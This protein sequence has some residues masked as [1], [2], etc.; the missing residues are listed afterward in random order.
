MTHSPAVI[1]AEHRE[2]VETL[3]NYHQMGHELRPTDVGIGLGSHDL[4]VAI[5]GTDLYHRGMYPILLFT[6]ANAPPTVEVFPRGEAVHYREYALEHGVPDEAIL[7]ETKAKH[8]AENIVLSREL[9]EERGYKDIETITLMSRPY[10]QRRGYAICKKLWPEV[11][12]IC[13]SNP[14][15]IDDYFTFIGNPKKI[16]DTMVGD[17]QRIDTWAEAGWA[18]PQPMPDEIRAAYERL[19]S[20][21]FTSRLVS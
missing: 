3:W 8:T 19:V 15:P 4:G 1:P 13:A 11:D 10:Q 18:I 21:G 12:V 14:L 6:G 20:A 2:D 17:T 9:L 5:V 7:I 16:I